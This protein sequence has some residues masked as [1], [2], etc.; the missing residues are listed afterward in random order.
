MKRIKR[1]GI[2]QTAKVAA[3]IYFLIA[4]I[5]MIPV[6]LISL[7]FGEEAFAGTP[8]GGVAF[9]VFMP[10]AYAVFAFIFTALG[11]WVYNSIANWIGGIE[12]ETEDV[13]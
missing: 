2:L 4:A 9:F 5:V 10:F 6:T 1:F 12:I 3:V 11:C 7:T 13:G 8:F